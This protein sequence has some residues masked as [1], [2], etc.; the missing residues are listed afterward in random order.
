MKLAETIEFV[1]AD[2][3]QDVF[4]DATARAFVGF[5]DS[6]NVSLLGMPL[7]E[8]ARLHRELYTSWFDALGEFLRILGEAPSTENRLKLVVTYLR[9]MTRDL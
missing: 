3:G 7:D 2:T 5:L 6:H 1:L 8:D 9:Y 4:D